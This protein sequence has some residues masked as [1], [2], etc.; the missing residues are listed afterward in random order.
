MNV[1]FNTNTVL[2][3]K[4][5]SGGDYQLSKGIRSEQKIP[6]C[7]IQGFKKFDK[8]KYLGKEYF[9]KGRMSTG[10]V[11]LMDIQGNKIDF[12]DAPKVMRTPK[13][14]NMERISARKSWI[15]SHKIIPSIC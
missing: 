10:Y 2:I 14:K 9:I 5:V 6:T 4:C 8:V 3:K 15:I 1:S 13:M 7:K 11:I 12:K